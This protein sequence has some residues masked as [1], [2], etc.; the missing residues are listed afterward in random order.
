MGGIYKIVNKINNKYYV[1]SSY[2]IIHR[3]YLHK[4]NL[5]NCR[6]CNDKLQ[7]AW[8]KYGAENFDFIIID[9]VE[10]RDTLL[11]V[12]QKYLNNAFLEKDKV[13]NINF[14]VDKVNYTDEVRKKISLS[15]KG[16]K[17]SLETIKKIINSNKTRVYSSETR[18]K[19]G[20]SHKGVKNYRYISTVYNFINKNTGEFFS[21]T[22][23]DLCHKFGIK[24][25]GHLHEMCRGDRKSVYGWK[26][27][28]NIL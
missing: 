2:D 1:G 28:K 13:Y 5:K 12:E 27:E 7:N 19:I 6:H 8:N 25:S 26:L 3:F 21:G 9:R 4:L 11:D 10:N 22:V 18:E 17:H 24:K 23:C 15:S 14:L 16:R 20:D